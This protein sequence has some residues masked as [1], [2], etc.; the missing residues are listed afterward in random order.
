M[1]LSRPLTVIV[2]TVDADVLAVLAR[3]TASF[4]GRQVHQIAGRHSE[5]GVR[6]ALDRLHR[7]RDLL[8]PA[9]PASSG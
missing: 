9:G 1:D 8:Y 6:I 2:P 4:T 7:R 5:R 3:A